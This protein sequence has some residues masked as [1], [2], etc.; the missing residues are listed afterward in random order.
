VSRL[1]LRAWQL[2]EDAFFAMSALSPLSPVEDWSP[3]TGYQAYTKAGPDTPPVSSHTS[4]STSGS[5][6]MARRQPSNGNPSPPSSVAG[7]V[8]SR[9]AYMI[10]EQLSEHYGVLKNY[11]APYLRDEKPNQQQNRARDKL[12]R[13]SAVQFQELSTDVYD[14]LIRREDEK[15]EP[16]Q[17]PPPSGAPKY[18]VPKQN[19]HFK[20]NQARQKLSTLPNDRFRQLATDVFYELERRYPRFTSGGRPGS[21]A[22]SL[23]GSIMSMDPRTGTPNGM[24][25]PRTDSRGPIDMRGLLPRGPSSLSNGPPPGIQPGLDTPSNG[26]PTPKTFQSNTIVPNKGTLVEDDGTGSVADDPSNDGLVAEYK[27]QI[28]KLEGKVDSLQS[29]LTQKTVELEKVSVGDSTL[30]VERAEWGGLRRNL[31]QKLQEAQ[32]LNDTLQAEL[33]KLRDHNAAVERDLRLQLDDAR[34][35]ERDLERDLRDQLDQARRE[36]LDMERDLRAQLENMRLNDTQSRPQADS[37]PEEWQQRCESLEKQVAEQQRTTDEVRREASQFLQEMRILSEQS[38]EAFEKEERLLDQVSQLEREVREWKSRYIKTKTRERSLRASS[39]GLPS[40]NGE[41]PQY[42]QFMS[43]DG[44]VKDF[45]VTNYQLAID[46]LLQLARKPDVNNAVDGCMKQVVMSVRHISN[47]VDTVATPDG[48]LSSTMMGDLKD[49]A[50]TKMRLSQTCNNLITA[51][52]NHASADGLSPVSLVDA[53]SS[54][55]TA[56]VIDMIRLVKIRPTPPE[57][58]ERLEQ[59]EEDGVIAAKPVPLQIGSGRS[60]SSFSEDSNT[61]NRQNGRLT[62]NGLAVTGHTRNVSSMSSTGYSAYSR[63]SSRYSNNTNGDVNGRGLGISQ[64]M[65]MLRESG[66][67]EFKVWLHESSLATDNLIPFYR[68]ILKIPQ[69]SS[70]APFNRSSTPFETQPRPWIQP[71][72]P[73]FRN[74]SAALATLFKISLDAPMMPCTISDETQQDLAF[75]NM[76]HL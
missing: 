63:Y 40:A 19:F 57:E 6:D 4:A 7:S 24:R 3:V 10:E 16:S 37:V 67:E 41:S 60:K 36:G 29:E 15:K 49:Q 50:R 55:L 66:I 62:P 54:N 61:S 71:L 52:K 47:D 28:A 26:R 38:S 46:E 48:T 23:A 17:R 31:E 5:N 51:V 22:P 2:P 39:L 32:T 33:N 72:N 53:A 11:L 34:R 45:H 44:L 64:A 14:E 56:A 69:R 70:F 65:D 58:L 18:L 68:T 43:P 42:S 21:L 12:I 73:Q 74:T 1:H 59:E 30:E 25:P 35:S 76:R 75:R 9:R 27:S 13:L 8:D 20:R